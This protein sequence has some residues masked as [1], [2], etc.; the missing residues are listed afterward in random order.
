YQKQN[1]NTTHDPATHLA[2]GAAG[3]LLLSILRLRYAWWPLHPIGYL[4]MMTWPMAQLWFSIMLGWLVRTV[5]LRFGGAKL[6]TTLQPAMMGLIIGE[7]IASATWLVLGLL[8]S[9]AGMSFYPIR[10]TLY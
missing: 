3:T 2:G 9:S 6:Y 8:F 10:F 1:Y 4:F 7:A 5:A